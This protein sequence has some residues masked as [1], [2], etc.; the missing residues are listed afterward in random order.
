MRW[1]FIRFSQLQFLLLWTYIRQSRVERKHDVIW[2]GVSKIQK[3]VYIFGIT[4][5]EGIAP[6]SNIII[7]INT[8]LAKTWKMIPFTMFLKV[9]FKWK[10]RVCPS[11]GMSIYKFCPFTDL[12]FFFRARPT[13]ASRLAGDRKYRKSKNQKTLKKNTFATTA[14]EKAGRLAD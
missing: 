6:I 7:N 14:D 9:F 10:S 8:K 3:Y 1:V 2:H 13:A 11:M 4:W 12:Q 5:R